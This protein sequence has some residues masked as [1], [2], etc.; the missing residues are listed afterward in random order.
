MKKTSLITTVACSLLLLGM[1]SAWAQDQ[2][3]GA[4]ANAPAMAS[5]PQGYKAVRKANRLLSKNVLRALVKVKGMDSTNIV[6]SAKN[7]AILLG[8]TVPEG[9]QIQMAVAA[10]EGVSGVRSVQNAL[11]VNAIGQ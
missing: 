9:D 6:V 7:G 4:A 5:T 10:A 1:A 3:S 8:G 2:G 11:R